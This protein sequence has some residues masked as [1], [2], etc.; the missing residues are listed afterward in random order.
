MI[1]C[2][3]PVA[4]YMSQREEILAALTKVLDKG[5]YI[6]GPEVDAFE[7]AFAKYCGTK[8]GIGLNSGTDALILSLKALGVRPGDEVVTVSHTALAT[9]S[10]ILALEAVP[11]LVDVNP[12][13]YTIDVVKMEQAITS[14]TKA[15]I[16]VHI[17]GQSAQLEQILKIAEHKN[18][19]VIED[20]A[21]ST[22]GFYQGKR[23]GSFGTVGCFS[24]YPTKNLGAIGD[25]GMVVTND[26]I[27]NTKIRRLRQYGWDEERNTELPG[28]NSRLDELQAAILNVKL[29]TLDESNQKRIKI[30]EAYSRELSSLSLILPHANDFN[31]HVYHLYVI[32][33]QQ[34][35]ELKSYLESQGILAGIHYPIPAHLHGG[36]KAKCNLNY[37]NMNITDELSQTVLSL[38]IYPELSMENVL[39]VC[40]AIKDFFKN[41]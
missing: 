28:L 11:V 6:L 31:E 10:A 36:Y 2:A 27:I 35:N 22:G 13:F 19:P 39:R 1:N 16:V 34:R 15:I 32:R 41:E 21:Q 17:Y 24:F 12:K 9:V 20:C 7:Q 8:H 29:K 23:V 40:S 37:S 26:S 14:K 3:N 33:L 5:P 38:P 25:G 30:A 4:Q 18:V